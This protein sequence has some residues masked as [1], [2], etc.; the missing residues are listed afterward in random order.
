MAKGTT[1]SVTKA[2]AL[3]GRKWWLVD[4]KDQTVGRLASRVATILKGKHKPAYTPSIDTGDFVVVVN[5]GGVKFTGKKETEKVFF[6][7]TMHP[8]GAKLTPM[9]DIRARHPEDLLLNAV[10]RMMPR[11][12]LG[13]QMMTKLKVYAGKEHPHAAQKPEALT[14][15]Q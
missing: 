6:S 12:A 4:A 3:K 8:G 11:N 7:H 1:H 2:E 9:S 5:A 13:R 15:G 14:L 10:R